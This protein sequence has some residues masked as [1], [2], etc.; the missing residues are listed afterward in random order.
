[1]AGTAGRVDREQ[2]P[3]VLTRLV[4]VS[5]SVLEVGVRG[6]GEPVLLVQTALYAEE[7]RPLADHLHRRGEYRVVLEHRRGYGRSGP[8][9]RPGSI[10]RDAE[11]CLQILDALEIERAHVVGGS[12]AGAVA[13]QLSVVA[14]DRVH[15]LCLVEPPPLLGVPDPEF[16]AACER[17]VERHRTDGVG[18]ALDAFLR[19]LVG[20][21]WR[22]DVDRYLP[23]GAAQVERDADTFFTAD[24][25]ALLAWHLAEEQLRAITQP[26]LY[27]GG[28]SSGPWFDHVHEVVLAL[29]PGA[30]DVM[31]PDAD[32]SLALTHTA[33]LA[34]AV[35]RFLRRHPITH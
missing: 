30:E 4:P 2:V 24:V 20:A 15:S 35:V 17:L 12:Y 13:L 21:T 34:T 16:V 5:D 26:V 29:L 32:H 11:D 25:P 7:F 6:T 27:V 23:G 8:P 31:I 22:S 33:Q 3:G 18:L 9:L 19:G 14:P 28:T 1:M 10:E